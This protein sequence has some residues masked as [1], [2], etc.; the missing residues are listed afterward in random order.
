[1]KL[2][3][4][5]VPD[6][7]NVAVLEDRVRQATAGHPIV[8][9]ISHRVIDDPDEAAA[10]G[11]AGSPTLLVDGVDP[12]AV[13]GQV[14]SVSCRLYRSESGGMDGAPSVGALRAALR[15][16]PSDTPEDSRAAGDCCPPSDT[17]D[18]P[19]SGLSTWRSAAQPADAAGKA[20]HQAVLRGFA[21]TG[22]PP[23][24]EELA[25]IAAR[26][27]VSAASVLT[28]LHE[29]DVIRLDTAGA[30]ASA[31]PFSTSPTPHRVRITDGA[32]V[33]AM[34]AVDALGMPAMLGTDA[35]IT[36]ADPVTS[37]P[38]EIA[39][40]AGELTAQPATTVV[41]LGARAGSGP[42][43]DS[44]CNDLNF[45]TDRDTAQ[46]WS[47]AHPHL[48]GAILDLAAA[49]R[50]GED[51]FGAQLFATSDHPDTVPPPAPPQC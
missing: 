42:S 5:Q 4:L 47:D 31:Y 28:H 39:I 40:R 2:E 34:C 6:C 43:A 21:A 10:A 9:E 17:T 26:F 33:Y 44:C 48:D 46:R 12:F 49:R 27:D 1:M 51:I 23:S 36:S 11:M 37:D 50:L 14:P 13:P 30:I 29:A 3:I 8:L 24:T 38:V 22:R 25:R 7:P 32:T 18:S 15:L 35:V 19:A 45:F 20:I 41:F 16:G